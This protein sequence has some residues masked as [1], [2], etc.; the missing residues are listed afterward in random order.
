[1]TQLNQDL[2]SIEKLKIDQIPGG[3]KYRTLSKCYDYL[4]HNDVDPDWEDLCNINDL[5]D[6][7]DQWEQAAEVEI[8]DSMYTEFYC[9]ICPEREMED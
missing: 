8:L 2:N 3:S 6:G 7:L 1:M 5:I 4:T 9:M